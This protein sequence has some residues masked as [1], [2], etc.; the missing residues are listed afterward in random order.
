MWDELLGV[1]ENGGELYKAVC[2]YN[3][4]TRYLR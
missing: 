1:G 2:T 3:I 4:H